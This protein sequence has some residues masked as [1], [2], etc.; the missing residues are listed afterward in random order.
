MKE[1]V[2]ESQYLQTIYH[3]ETFFFFL[4]PFFFVRVCN[5]PPSVCLN[6]R[7]NEKK[8]LRHIQVFVSCRVVP[9][10]AGVTCNLEYWLPLR[11]AKFSILFWKIVDP[12]FFIMRKIL[13]IRK[14][15]GPFH[16]NDF[17]VYGTTLEK[18][19]QHK[20]QNIYKNFELH[21]FH[22]VFV[23]I[24]CHTKKTDSCSPM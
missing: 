22:S 16:P 4:K 23:E 21:F 1:R 9:C 15:L 17:V 11:A 8:S 13:S 2:S 19:A 3:W 18:I 14:R 6:K 12:V 24:Y 7:K 10:N 20:E 5:F